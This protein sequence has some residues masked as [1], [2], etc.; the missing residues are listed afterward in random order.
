MKQ[1]YYIGVD[2]SK[3]KIDIAV[4]GNDYK[5][6]IEK[7]VQNQDAKIMSFFTYL[8]KKLKIEN[9]Q[10]LVCCEETGIYKR[11][12]QRAC[13]DLGIDVWVEVAIKIKR[14]STSLRGKSNKQDAARIA[15]SACRYNDKKVIYKEAGTL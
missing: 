3:E 1:I 4:M 14:E 10:L 13:L 7:V 6:L 9:S 15:E 12:L 5:I 11:P 2:I 8:I